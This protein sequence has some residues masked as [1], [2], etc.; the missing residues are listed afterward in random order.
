MTRTS[1]ND[2]CWVKAL[3]FILLFTFHALPGVM[4]RD[5]I[6]QQSLLFLKSLS[7][8]ELSL[9]RWRQLSLCGKA[10]TQIPQNWSVFLWGLRIACSHLSIETAH[11]KVLEIFQSLAIKTEHFEAQ[12]QI[13]PFCLSCVLRRATKMVRGLEGKRN[14]Q[15]LRFLG[16][17]S[18]KQRSI[19]EAWWWLQLLTGS[20]FM[21]FCLLYQHPYVVS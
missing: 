18:P 11:L 4:C 7:S 16:L 15:W 2:C 10:T 1:T 13:Q 17:L 19:R 20:Y 14:E 9:G 3:R 12:L 6:K 8:E 21:S 5:A